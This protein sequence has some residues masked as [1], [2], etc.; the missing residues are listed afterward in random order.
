MSFNFFGKL[1]FLEP[2]L[3]WEIIRR[4]VASRVH[5][6]LT[7]ACF[8]ASH[9]RKYHYAPYLSWPHPGATGISLH[10]SV[11]SMI[12]HSDDCLTEEKMSWRTCSFGWELP[13][14]VQGM[15][16]MNVY[17]VVKVPGGVLIPSC[18]RSR[19]GQKYKVPG[20]LFDYFS[21][22]ASSSAANRMGGLFRPSCAI[23]N[24]AAKPLRCTLAVECAPTQARRTLS[25]FIAQKKTQPP[26]LETGSVVLKRD[27]TM[28]K[29][30]GSRQASANN[31]MYQ[32][33]PSGL[34]G[35]RTFSRLPG[36]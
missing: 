35:Q 9:V 1:F 7:P 24:L 33:L 29:N 36:R 32:Y 18:D 34:S 25:C 23:H 30:I 28:I 3:P 5:G 22:T 6:P 21:C 4:P 19:E 12:L 16:L 31:L 11:R 26:T 14:P 15:Y 13:L 20:K 17:S 27:Q 2:H 10:E 8:V